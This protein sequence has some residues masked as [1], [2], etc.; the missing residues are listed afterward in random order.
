ML[1][2]RQRHND[3]WRVCHGWRVRRGRK[4]DH[5]PTWVH[6]RDNNQRSPKWN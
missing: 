2:W 4:V 6:R 5:I 3:L 1:T